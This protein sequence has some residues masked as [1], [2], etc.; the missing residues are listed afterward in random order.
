MWFMPIILVLRRLSRRLRSPCYIERS[1]SSWAKLS[2][3]CLSPESYTRA[4]SFK[5]I[6]EAPARTVSEWGS[7]SYILEFFLKLL[8]NEE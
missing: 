4:S 7:L 5:E 8:S 1:R 2:K 3:P 6:C